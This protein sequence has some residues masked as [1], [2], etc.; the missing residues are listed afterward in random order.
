MWGRWTVAAA[1][2][3]YQVVG[4]DTGLNAILAAKRVARRLDVE[5]TFVVGDARYMPFRDGSFDAVFSFGVLDHFSMDDSRRTLA[6]VARCLKPGGTCL[7]QL[8]RTFGL[9]S[10][11]RQARRRFRK[12]SGFAVPHW[13]VPTMRRTFRQLI[14]P[15]RLRADAFLNLNPQT[16]DLPLLPLVSRFTVRISE[17]LRRLSSRFPPLIH[18]ADSVYVEATNAR[19]GAAAPRSGVADR[20]APEPLRD[21]EAQ[22]PGG[23]DQALPDEGVDRVAVSRR[24]GRSGAGQSTGLRHRLSDPVVIVVTGLDERHGRRIDERV[25]MALR[26]DDLVGMPVQRQ[27]IAWAYEMFAQERTQ[28]S[29]LWRA[30]R[31]RDETRPAGYG[32]CGRREATQ[33]PA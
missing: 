16:A 19:V 23:R 9:L 27:M 2:S 6:E 33:I 15:T 24:G 20:I 22:V 11:V 26:A 21:G 29:I 14:G 4:I 7:I 5:A 12:R 8:A 30:R 10:I 31:D 1:R 3:G 32:H 13:T 17:T 25:G 18:L 28:R